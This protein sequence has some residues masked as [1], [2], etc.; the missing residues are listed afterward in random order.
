M[1]SAGD[2][3]VVAVAA[4]HHPLCHRTLFPECVEGV[5]QRLGSACKRKEA[6]LGCGHGFADNRNELEVDV[7]NLVDNAL[8]DTGETADTVRIEKGKAE[9]LMRSGSE[10]AAENGIL[11]QAVLKAFVHG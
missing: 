4:L 2:V 6:V 11:V 5:V 1:F 3:V 10:L 7:L 8:A 9:I